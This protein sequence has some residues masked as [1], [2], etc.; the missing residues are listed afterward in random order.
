MT[1]FKEQFVYTIMVEHIKDGL[2][3][4]RKA[5]KVPA[6]ADWIKIGS[7]L[8]VVKNVTWNFSDMRTVILL[9]DNPKI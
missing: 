4:Q 1:N 3:L 5:L 6:K 7:D 9:V 2:I 8:Y